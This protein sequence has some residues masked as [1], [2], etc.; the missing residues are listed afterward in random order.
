[1]AW[2]RIRAD[3]SKN[4]K[5]FVLSN[6]SGD[7]PHLVSELNRLRAALGSETVAMMQ[8]HEAEGSLDHPEYQ[9]ATRSSAIATSIGSRHCRH[10]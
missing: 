2:Y 5:T 1:L 8:R 6:T 4:L 7:M 3:L 9:A 10:R